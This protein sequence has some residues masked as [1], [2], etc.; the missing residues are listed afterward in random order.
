[1]KP[2]DQYYRGQTIEMI[3]PDKPINISPCY[4]SEMIR[5]FK[6][7][8]VVEIMRIDK[9]RNRIWIKDYSGCTWTIIPEWIEQ[10]E[11]VLFI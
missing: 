8:P 3:V 11:V 10:D 7:D 9:E 6:R 4:V 1:M 2:I 5:N